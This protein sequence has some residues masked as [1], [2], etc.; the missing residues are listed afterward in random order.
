MYQCAFGITLVSVVMID[1][2][3][4]ASAFRDR[5]GKALH[6]LGTGPRAERAS[7]AAYVDVSLRGAREE[8]GFGGCVPCRSI[9]D[10]DGKR[11]AAVILFDSL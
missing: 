2:S 6:T 10:A 5:L 3:E 11:L 1:H 8:G 7:V 4:L 9:W